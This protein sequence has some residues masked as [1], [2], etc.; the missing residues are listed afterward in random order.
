MR[1]R[2]F[3]KLSDICHVDRGRVLPIYLRI[4]Y[5]MLFPNI[6][7]SYLNMKRGDVYIDAPTNTIRIFGIKYTIELFRDFKAFREG[8]IFEVVK[9]YNDSFALKKIETP[10]IKSNATL[11]TN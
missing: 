10:K 3:N 5:F 7:L 6:F 9:V 2:I 8:D 11:P 4:I 1:R